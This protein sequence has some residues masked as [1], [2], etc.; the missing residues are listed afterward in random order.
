MKGSIIE[1]RASKVFLCIGSKDGAT[2]GQELDVFRVAIFLNPSDVMP[3]TFKREKSGKMRITQIVDEHFAE[4]VI[5]SGTA[6]VN[7]IVELTD[8]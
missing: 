4:A 5:I 8:H 3:L 6:G 1:A 7:S 2:V